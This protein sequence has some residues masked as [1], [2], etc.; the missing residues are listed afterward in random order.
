MQ[1]LCKGDQQGFIAAEAEDRRAGSWP[2][3]G[4]LA[5]L[6]IS[7]QDAGQ[8]D[9]AAAGLARRAPRDP[10]IEILGPAPAPLALLRGK[11]RRR[12]LVKSAKQ[13]NLQ[14][15]IRRWLGSIKLPNQVRVQIDIDPYS[16]M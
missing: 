4:R 8:V 13:V 11:H 9:Q 2:P 16:F 1:A 14:A 10:A 7:G 12:L 6:I 5:A 15:Y 3:F